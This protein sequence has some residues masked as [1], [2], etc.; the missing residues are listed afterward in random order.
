MPPVITQPPADA[1]AWVAQGDVI[2]TVDG[3]YVK[4]AATKRSARR[5]V[6]KHN[7]SL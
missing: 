5:Q 3:R 2:W 1:V 4:T 7:A 6:E